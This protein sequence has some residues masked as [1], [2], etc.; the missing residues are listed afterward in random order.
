MPTRRQYLTGLA[1]GLAVGTIARADDIRRYKN[2]SSLRFLT[3]PE[4]F[5]QPKKTE[6][7]PDLRYFIRHFTQRTDSAYGLYD[8][9]TDV[10]TVQRTKE[11]DCADLANFIASWLLH[12]RDTDV[13]L[14]VLRPTAEIA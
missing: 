1:G 8:V 6:H 3:A 14:L 13:Q 2:R 5:V 9:V 4:R 7:T 12:R 10:E 11:G